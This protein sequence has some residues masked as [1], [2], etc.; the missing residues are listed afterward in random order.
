MLYLL[1]SVYFRKLELW[2]MELNSFRSVLPI[3]FLTAAFS[4]APKGLKILNSYLL[5]TDSQFQLFS[6]DR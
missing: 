5:T 2:N 3:L 1:I 6:Q 4:D